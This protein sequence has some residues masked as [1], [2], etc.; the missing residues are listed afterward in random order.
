MAATLAD[1]SAVIL[2]LISL[3]RNIPSN[4]V[5]GTQQDQM[6]RLLTSVNEGNVFA[7]FNRI[8]DLLF[9][10]DNDCRNEHGRFKYLRQ[11][12]YGMDHLGTYL[13]QISWEDASMIVAYDLVKLRLDWLIDELVAI[14]CVFTISEQTFSNQPSPNSCD[15]PAPA[16][17]KTKAATKGKATAAGKKAGKQPGGKGPVNLTQELHSGA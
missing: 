8:F 14:G 7:T 1:I 9:K 13:Q 17:S 5:V 3:T 12:R 4:V 6:Y 15:T 10:E 11:G 2:C 16:K